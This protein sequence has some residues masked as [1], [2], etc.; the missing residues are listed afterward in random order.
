M[1]LPFL[2]LFR[3]LRRG[4][5]DA[6]AGNKKTPNLSAARQ[7]P[8]P[9]LRS[10]NLKV[11]NLDHQDAQVWSRAHLLR[12][13]RTVSSRAGGRGRGGARSS[14]RRGVPR[15]GVGEGAV[16][17]R[18]TTRRRGDVFLGACRRGRKFGGLWLYQLRAAWGATGQ[19]SGIWLWLWA[20]ASGGA[21]QSAS[22]LMRYIERERE[23]EGGGGSKQRQGRLRAPRRRNSPPSRGG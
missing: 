15:V 8:K 19:L 13:T 4:F 17:C 11:G 20:S 1:F 3:C 18:S 10:F 7:E 6:P 16:A 9:H 22:I 12:P 5:K 21:A 14:A 23:R 2:E